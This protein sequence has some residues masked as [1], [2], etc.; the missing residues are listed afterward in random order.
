[1]AV[2]RPGQRKTNDL[3]Y[4]GVDL[5]SERGRSELGFTATYVYAKDITDPARIIDLLGSA[6]PELS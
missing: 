3:G 6:L 2:S 4:C 5:I 1:M